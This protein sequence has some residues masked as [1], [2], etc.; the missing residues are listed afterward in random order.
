[1]SKHWK[2][3]SIPLVGC[4]LCGLF[5]V[6]TG[7]PVALTFFFGLGVMI[8]ILA[9]ARMPNN[10]EEEKNKQQCIQIKTSVLHSSEKRKKID[11]ERKF[12][13]KQ[14]LEAKIEELT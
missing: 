14:E 11:I 12:K 10:K 9:I 3:F 7:D 13:M 5:F 6:L 2:A 8:A 4:C 1:M